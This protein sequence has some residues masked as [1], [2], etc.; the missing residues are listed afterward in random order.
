MGR[1]EL[2]IMEH[3]SPRKEAIILS[4]RKAK[5]FIPILIDAKDAKETT[6]SLVSRN[7]FKGMRCA[8]LSKTSGEELRASLETLDI[9]S[10]RSLVRQIK[11]SLDDLK[12]GRVVEL[13]E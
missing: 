10:D 11:Q 8:E 5:E 3:G 4:K 1:Q 9:L 6:I 2:I 12:H 7:V 13:E